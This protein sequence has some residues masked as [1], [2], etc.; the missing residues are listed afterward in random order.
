MNEKD[1]NGSISYLFFLGGYI[2]QV[3]YCVIYLARLVQVRHVH[4][5]YIH[6]YHIIITSFCIETR[7][8][9]VLLP[10]LFRTPCRLCKSDQPL[11]G[12]TMALFEPK[13][14]DA[15]SNKM[16]EHVTGHA[17]GPRLLN[18]ER[19]LAPTWYLCISKL[20]GTLWSFPISS[21]TSHP[22]SLVL[23]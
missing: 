3:G 5:C 21:F 11:K 18:D 17:F 23:C 2:L 6:H 4:S 16:H 13:Y 14:C 12:A 8:S 1:G 9:C 10:L 15:E 22:D 19:A 7:L 20:L